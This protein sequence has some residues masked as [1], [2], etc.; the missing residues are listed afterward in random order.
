MVWKRENDTKERIG[1]KH[2]SYASSDLWL[3]NNKMENT[4]NRENEYNN[5]KVITYV[6]RI[7]QP[8]NYWGKRQMKLD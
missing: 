3:C 1:S 5:E 8:R 4:G 7:Y 2:V 6:E